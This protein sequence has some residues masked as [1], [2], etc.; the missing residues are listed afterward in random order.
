MFSPSLE[1]PPNHFNARSTLDPVQQVTRATRPV[2][3]AQAD[4]RPGDV[5]PV[6]I[7]PVQVPYSFEY[8]WRVQDLP[9][10]IDQVSALVQAGVHIDA[11]EVAERLGDL[12][13]PYA[14]N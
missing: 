11:R 2:G 12:G 7:T 3:V 5:V 10:Y 9:A 1:Y 14:F 8:D 13:M 6:Q 4:A